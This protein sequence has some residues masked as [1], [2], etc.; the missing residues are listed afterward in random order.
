M[1]AEFAVITVH[2]TASSRNSAE[3]QASMF[4][5]LLAVVYVG[6]RVIRC[7]MSWP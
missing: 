1:T 4:F 5:A 7:L 6:D 2:Y 3:N